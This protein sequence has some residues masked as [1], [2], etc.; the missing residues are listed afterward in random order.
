MAITGRQITVRGRV[1]GV[2]F[3]P[4][5][6]RL[7]REAQL[8]GHVLNDG[9][10]VTIVAWGPQSVLDGF[11]QRLEQSPPPLARIAELTWEALEGTAPADAFRIAESDIGAISAEITPDAATCPACIAEIHDPADRRYQY[12]FTNCTHCGP[13]LSIVRGIPYD[14]AQTSMDMFAMCDACR[15]EYLDPA[16]RRFH[17]QPNACPVCGP[18]I[19]LEDARGVIVSTDPLATAAQRLMRGEIIAIKGIGGFHLACNATDTVSVQRLRQRKSR[20]AKPFA[21]MA[22]DLEQIR[23]F[24]QLSDEE[25]ALLN[26]P[27]APIVLLKKSASAALPDI[28]PGLG[29]IGVMLPHAPLHHLLLAQTEAPLVMTSGNR[30]QTPQITRNDIARSRLAG[31]A[32]ALL[33]HD[34]DIVNRLDDSLIR[35]D[36][37]APSILRRGRGMAPAPISLHPDLADTSPTLAMGADL[38]ST[39]C[40]LN[41]GQA[42]P[43]QHIGDLQ[44]A[45]TYADYR[46]KIDLYR[47]LY[48]LVPEIIAVDIHP[49]YLSTRWGSRLANETGARLVRVQHHHAHMLACLA[50][51]QVAPENAL[52]VGIILDGTG[53]GTD[54][55][56]WGG[57][58][59]VGDYRGFQRKA[60]IQPVALAGGEK[61]VREPWRNL[62]AHLICAFG[63][64]WHRQIAQTPLAQQLADKPT[65]MISQMIVQGLNAPL[66]SSAGR[67]FDAVAAALG[68]A[69]G[70]QHY[71][72]QAAMELEAVMGDDAVCHGY[73]AALSDQGVISWK[74]LWSELVSD[75]KSGVA[76]GTI[77]SRFHIGLAD[78]LADTAARVARDAHTR[79]IVLSGGVMQNRFLQHR[80]AENLQARGLTVL[81]HRKLPANDGGIALGQACFAALRG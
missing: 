26:T 42:I 41:K 9:A 76:H 6:W 7:A 36:H 23:R 5:V 70:K 44:T 52:S 67:L 73:S 11:L 32:D 27:A 35:M 58:I 30:A 54:G 12:P 68:I 75:L 46:A 20:L 29:R 8:T 47:A 50:E 59:M 15:R 62:V 77:A 65:A 78:V 80:I 31:I 55:T 1:Q 60:H 64:D 69:F 2:G 18:K 38:K 74:P 72:G 3:R 81:R 34:R 43:S 39:F 48:G 49:D 71:E 61:A 22:R 66:S 17:A 14:R 33:M 57:E 51:H 37:G 56:L 10:G 79:Q 63:D 13:R 21:V 24:C 25:A 16:D 4:F 45:E 19:W 40:L 28:A 53:M